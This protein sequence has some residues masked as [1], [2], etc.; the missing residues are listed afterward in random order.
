VPIQ[1]SVPEST[2]ADLWAQ[3]ADEPWMARHPGGGRLFD[4]AVF[5]SGKL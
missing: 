2:P 1:L 4:D 5:S 3:W